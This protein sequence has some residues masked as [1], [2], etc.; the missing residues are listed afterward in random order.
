MKK[1]F[2][3]YREIRSQNGAVEDSDFKIFWLI[4]SI[5]VLQ[6]TAESHTKW[7][8]HNLQV[9]WALKVKFFCAYAVSYIPSRLPLSLVNKNFKFSNSTINPTIFWLC[10]LFLWSKRDILCSNFDIYRLTFL[11]WF[12]GWFCVCLI[13]ILKI[14]W[15]DTW[16]ETDFMSEFVWLSRRGKSLNKRLSL[17]K[18]S[19]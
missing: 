17:K 1:N 16:L 3:R 6:C 19:G 11:L 15:G 7:W 5:F 10:K 9:Q 18:S 8:T 13:T 2:G 14:K 4:C 12:L